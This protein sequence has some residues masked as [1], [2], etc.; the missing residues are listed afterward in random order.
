MDNN[1]L[2]NYFKENS[3]RLDEQP[4]ADLWAKIEAGL[5]ANPTPVKV[6]GKG[7]F[8][9]GKGL[10][11]II[12]GII[13]IA[14]IVLALLPK[15]QPKQHLLPAKE[16]TATTAEVA[17]INDTASVAIDVLPAKPQRVIVEKRVPITPVTGTQPVDTIAAII[18]PITV[19]QPA[20]LIPRRIKVTVQESKKR[21]VLT[22][23]EKIAP[24]KFDSIVAASLIEYKDMAGM[25]LIVKD[26]EGHIFRHTYP[27]GKKLVV[28]GSTADTIKPRPIQG[29]LEVDVTLKPTGNNLTPE[30]IHFTKTQDSTGTLIMPRYFVKKDSIQIKR[31]GKDHPE[32]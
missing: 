17:P 29:V 21:T 11:L 20:V 13:G 28:R 6:P 30:T 31:D 10:A 15:E 25:Q 12:F 18:Q 1:P 22:I 19:A 5:D 32:D 23:R 2:D 26:V 3:H 16:V 7:G 14:G 9:S 27:V 8:F 24:Y 4:G